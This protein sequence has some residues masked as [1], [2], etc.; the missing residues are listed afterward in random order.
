METYQILLLI[1]CGLLLLAATLGSVLP[2]LPGPPIGYPG[3]LVAHFFTPVSFSIF[4]LIFYGLFTLLVLAVDYWIP[5]YWVKKSGGTKW[6]SNGSIAGMLL[7]MF[8]LPPLG[9][10]IG[11]FLGAVIGEL[12][13]GQTNKAALKSGVATFLG[14]L[15]GTL[16]KL[17]FCLLML[18][19]FISKLF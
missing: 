17:V 4:A 6:G 18:I 2:I 16:L 10:L 3:L 1:F 11:T 14:F 8:F 9:M 12:W 19:H 13:A 7:G 5:A 15:A